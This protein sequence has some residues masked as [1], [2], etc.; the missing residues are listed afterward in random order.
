VRQQNVFERGEGGDELVGLKNEPDLLAANLCKTVFFEV[1]DID[2]VEEHFA[3]A[4]RVETGEK[5]KES[6][7]TAP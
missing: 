2:T 5:A 7:L 6:A 3:F 1:A 4:G